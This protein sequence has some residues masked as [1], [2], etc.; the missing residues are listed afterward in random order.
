MNF[1]LVDI[2]F[3]FTN[4]R[5]AFDS[6]QFL[7][8]TVWKIEQKRDLPR[9]FSDIIKCNTSD[10]KQ[11]YDLPIS[12]INCYQK[13]K[14]F[15]DKCKQIRDGINHLSMDTKAVF[16]LED[17]FALQKSTFLNEPIT[18]YFDIWIPEKIK[19]ND[20]VSVLALYAYLNQS[21]LDSTESFSESLKES[22]KKVSII[23][24]KYNLFLRG[25]YLSHLINSNK[26]LEEQWITK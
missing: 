24:S 3:L 7:I 18:R 1:V 2:E 10:F 16:C 22:V 12:L 8:S 11:K 23:S 9:H 19:E 4:I 21:F 15:F 20:L 5:S 13:S 25:P 6:L 17:G 26:Y 14:D